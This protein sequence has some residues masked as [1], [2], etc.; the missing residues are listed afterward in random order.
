MIKE[1]LLNSN[2]FVKNVYLG[3]DKVAQWVR[4][5]ALQAWAAESELPGAT[6]K[7]SRYSLPVTPR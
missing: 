1:P 2:L 7:Q 5:S 6:S 4:E 3:A